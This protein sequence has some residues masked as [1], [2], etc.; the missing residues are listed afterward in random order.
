MTGDGSF[1][2]V[3]AGNEGVGKTSLIFWLIQER[4]VEGFHPT[5]GANVHD[6]ST[7]VGDSPCDVKLW[8]TAGQERYKSLAPIYFRGAHAAVIV[9]EAR[10]LD[11]LG[12]VE[13]WIKE[14]RNV[15]GPDADVIVAANKCDLVADDEMGALVARTK[16]LAGKLGVEVFIVSA[17]TGEN[18]RAMFQAIA[19]K[20][21]LKSPQHILARDTY[22][23]ARA[24][25]C[26]C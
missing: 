15:V 24:T 16:E 7:S 20:V 2:I 22:Q 10:N 25:Q 14:F 19:E 13:A 5:V 17:K 1:K 6:W 26:T 21:V 11:P 18:V 4:F 8:D 3:L 9:F 23:E 12:D